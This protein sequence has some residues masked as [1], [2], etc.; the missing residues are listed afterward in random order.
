MASNWPDFIKSDTN[1]KY[2]NPWHYVDIEKNLAFDAAVDS[3]KADTSVNAYNRILFLVKQLKNKALSLNEKQMYLKLLIHIVGDV[4]QPFHAGRKG[5]RGGNDIKVNWFNDQSNLHR[6]W[7]E[8]LISYQELS[9]TEYT[10]VINFPTAQQ[11]NNWQK[12]SI[13]KWLFE[14]YTIS[15]QLHDDVKPN[16]K[17]GFNYNFK[18]VKTLNEQLLKG[19]V[20]LAGLLNEIFG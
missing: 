16:D 19:G 2:L 17:L 6:V 7:D 20:R 14:S 1:Y 18:H 15:E 13:E 12:D 11:K 9:Y 5:D 4:H 8:Q 3:M 10:N